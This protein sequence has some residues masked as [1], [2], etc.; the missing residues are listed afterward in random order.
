MNPRLLEHYRRELQHA[1]EM[2]G[3]FA[4]EF[5]KIAGRLG[6]ETMECSDPYV[7]RLLEGF[8]FL[9]ARVQLKIEF[10]YSKLARHLLEMV[11][12]SY[13]SPTPSMVVV[14]MQPSM[15]EGSLEQGYTI[16]RGTR[17]RSQMA[18]DEQTECD[19][20]T[21]H[22][23]TLWPIEIIE[24][25]ILTS[26]SAI[27]SAG[28]RVSR[29]VRS[30]LALKLSLPD[31]M[32]FSQVPIDEL[33][34]YLAGPDN[35]GARLYEHLFAHTCQVALLSNGKELRSPRAAPSI[36][37]QGYEDDEALLPVLA[38]SF[39]GYRLLQEY[40]AFPER[41]QFLKVKNLLGRLASLDASS[42]EVVFLFDTVDD[43]IT[44]LY[45]V[46]N[47]KLN[48][49]PA[50]NLFPR[51][52]DR[53]H[54]HKA[55]HE[56]HIV[57][58]RTRPMDFEVYSVEKVEGFG[59]NQSD[60]ETFY[61]YFSV[62]EKRR[63]AT[64]FFSVHREPREL[65]SKQ[66][67]QGP[68]SSSYVGSEAYLS[69]VDSSEAPY[70]T[71]MRQLAIEALCTNRDLPIQMPVGKLDTD[72]K[73]DI[74]AP[75]DSVRCVAGP[76]LPKASRA[77]YRDAWSLVSNLSTNYLSIDTGRD[78]DGSSGAALLRQ[79]LE[80]YT[81]EKSGSD[82]RQLEGIVS[83]KTQPAVRQRMFRGRVELAHGQEI[84]LTLDESAF[85]GTGAYLL[86]SVLER[87]FARHATINSF[88]ETVL[89]TIQRNEVE[90]WPVRLGQRRLI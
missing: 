30:A 88:T 28:V 35:T 23:V 58:D 50:I 14:E 2:G 54:L 17:M 72:F 33:S 47:F 70:R 36:H 16:P 53:L 75:V 73:F 89:E 43:S 77:H 4:E 29:E 64:S 26:R 76:T 83:I 74:G 51:T 10:S 48:C 19:F 1:R 60:T 56:Y 55:R 5:P 9:A 20:R 44:D 87:F 84:T 66:K 40:F 18:A 7:E 80:L 21:S 85:Q 22:D 79:M 8:A 41:F 42:V 90:R 65:S 27:E 3:E 81:D 63:T 6:L 39:Q 11:Y 59:T 71:N 24:A 13:L 45:D 49:V 32:L 37:R 82:R 46:S 61:P 38:K 78:D 62:S 15:N 34:F 67:K 12:P 52:L 25:R 57:P 68:R 31:G 86:G 69:L